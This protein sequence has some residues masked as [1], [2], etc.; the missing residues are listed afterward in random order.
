MILLMALPIES[1]KASTSLA[2]RIPTIS[3]LRK[4]RDDMCELDKTSVIHQEAT[5]YVG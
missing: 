4:S 3:Q 2:A 5:M 1:F